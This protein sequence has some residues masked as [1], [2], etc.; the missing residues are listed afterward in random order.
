VKFD[1]LQ[2]VG[3]VLTV[4]G[5]QGAIRLLLDHGNTGLLTWLGAGFAGTLVC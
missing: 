2:T 3:A 5:A 4:L 1:V